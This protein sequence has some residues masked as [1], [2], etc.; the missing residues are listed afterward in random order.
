MRKISAKWRQWSHGKDAAIASPSHC[1]S[2][3]LR[4]ATCK[5]DEN[6]ALFTASEWPHLY[7]GSHQWPIRLT[8][9]NQEIPSELELQTSTGPITWHNTGPHKKKK[10]RGFSYTPIDL[11]RQKTWDTHQGQFA[12]ISGGKKNS[13]KTNGQT[14]IRQ[15]RWPIGQ[16][17]NKNTFQFSTK[18]P[19][20][21]LVI[22]TRLDFCSPPFEEKIICS[23]VIWGHTHKQTKNDHH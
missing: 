7:V 13:L 11:H 6:E 15:E 18:K 23:E 20:T 16:L 3:C 22:N 10:R 5:W 9:T 19:S 17:R 21:K 12:F 4:A 14:V 2:G 8:A 1:R